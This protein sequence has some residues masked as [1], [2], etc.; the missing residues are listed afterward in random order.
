MSIFQNQTALLKIEV[1]SSQGSMPASIYLLW[2]WPTLTTVELIRISTDV[3]W[4]AC[5]VVPEINTCDSW[6]ATYAGRVW[7]TSF[8][9]A[10]ARRQCYGSAN[11]FLLL[12]VGF[13]SLVFICS[14]SRCGMG[15]CCSVSGVCTQAC[16]AAREL[17]EWTV[18]AF[19]TWSLTQRTKFFKDIEVFLS[20]WSEKPLS[21][22][23]CSVHVWAVC[24]LTLSIATLYLVL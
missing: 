17:P 22:T 6:R 19:C 10:S 21:N 9:C 18:V 14:C 23:L 12:C 1:P 11:C 24:V 16:W 3:P 2:C 4:V 7:P 8:L 15:V 5:L 20:M 13:I